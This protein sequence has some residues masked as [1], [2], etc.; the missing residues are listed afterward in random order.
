MTTTT[1]P[2]ISLPVEIVNHI[3]SYCQSITNK[4]MKDH[5]DCLDQVYQDEKYL[6]EVSYDG[7]MYDC[8]A[9]HLR[10]VLHLMG[11]YGHIHFDKDKFYSRY[12]SCVNCRRV[13]YSPPYIEF[14]EKFCNSYCADMFDY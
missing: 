2:N 9:N 7:L 1:T 5:I 11:F 4:I 13:G 10:Y 8:K 6:Y 14:G 3:F 12:Y